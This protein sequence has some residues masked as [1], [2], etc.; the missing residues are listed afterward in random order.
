V[1]FKT[2]F[3]NGAYASVKEKIEDAMRDMEF[4]DEPS[5]DDSS[6]KSEPSSGNNQDLL[7]SGMDL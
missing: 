4:F 7:L 6:T 2:A 3:D 5:A 1:D